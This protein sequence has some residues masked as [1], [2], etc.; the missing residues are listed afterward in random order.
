MKKLRATLLVGVLSTAFTLPVNAHGLVYDQGQYDSNQFSEDIVYC[1]GLGLQAPQEEAD[2]VV[3]E[4]AKRGARGATAGAVAG[5]VSGNSGSDAA[6][7][8]A[9]IGMTLGILGNRG[10]RNAVEA[11]NQEAYSEVVRNCMSGRGYVALN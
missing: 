4:T 9:A 8:G 10:K 11:S 3:Q 5:S 6:K 1:E 2:N 7:T